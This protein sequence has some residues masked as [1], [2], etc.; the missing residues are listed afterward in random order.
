LKAFLD[1][2]VLIAVFQ[3]EHIHHAASLRVFAPL[4]PPTGCC[5]SH[6]IV[7]LYST[8][9]RMPAKYRRS[10]DEV[11]L[12]VDTVHQHLSTISLSS[13]EYLAALK[14]AS[15]LGITGGAVYDAMLAQCALKAGAE[16]IYTWNIKHYAQCGQDVVQRLRTP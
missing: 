11:M 15:A 12:V 1:T 14:S 16:I 13:D 10:I 7:E 5:A 2:N 4:D 3:G 9:T 8:L 6:T